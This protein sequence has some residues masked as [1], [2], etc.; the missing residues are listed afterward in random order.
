[1][2]QCDSGAPVPQG[3][4]D[5]STGTT[6]KFPAILGEWGS[7]MNYTGPY[8]EEGRVCGEDPCPLTC[9]LSLAVTI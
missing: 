3:Y 8:P 4:T 2:P 1:M 6:C 7:F 9:A 5:T